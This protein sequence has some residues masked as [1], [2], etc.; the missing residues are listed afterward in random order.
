MAEKEKVLSTGSVGVYCRVITCCDEARY[1]AVLAV[2][3]NA[4]E[5][6]TGCVLRAVAGAATPDRPAIAAQI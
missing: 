6:D 5:S 3:L 1:A 2:T 4:E